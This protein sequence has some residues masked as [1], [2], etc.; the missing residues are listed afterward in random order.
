MTT[1]SLAHTCRVAPTQ[2]ATTGEC[3]GNSYGL[4]A[5]GAARTIKAGSIHGAWLCG[6][7]KR[8]PAFF[9]IGIEAR[10]FL[11]GYAAIPIHRKSG[12]IDFV[13]CWK[14]NVRLATVAA[15]GTALVAS[16]VPPAMRASLKC[17]N[18][19]SLAPRARL[20]LNHRQAPL[21]QEARL[22]NCP[23]SHNCPPSPW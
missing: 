6:R 3:C 16:Q 21:R 11:V 20:Q 15:I 4:R 14:R 13:R 8:I 7:A 22:G 18:V 5:A 2:S 10:I 23:A 12:N 17:M 9:W 19:C 1:S